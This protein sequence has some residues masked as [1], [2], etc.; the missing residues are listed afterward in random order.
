MLEWLIAAAAC[1]GFAALEVVF[2]GRRPQRFLSS[3]VQPRWAPSL[4]VWG[5][6][7]VGYYLACLIGLAQLMRAGPPAWPALF[8]LVKIM[9]A[10]AFWNLLFF[11][12]R[13]LRLAFYYS[14]VYGLMVLAFVALAAPLDRVTVGLWAI[15][16]AYQVYALTLLHALARLNSEKDAGFSRLVAALR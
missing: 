9:A 3:L 2:A 5:L 4:P 11:R 10:N 7:A 14:L 13:A 15:Y 1:A 8:L 16:A 6:I 12:L